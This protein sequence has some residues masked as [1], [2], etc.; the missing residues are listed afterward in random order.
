MFSTQFAD[1]QSNISIRTAT[2][3]ILI[4][5]NAAKVINHLGKSLVEAG[6]LENPPPAACFAFHAFPHGNCGD[7]TVWNGMMTSYL[8]GFHLT[9]AKDESFKEHL[10]LTQSAAFLAEY[11]GYAQEKLVQD[12]Q[13]QE[14]VQ[15]RFGRYS[16]GACGNVYPLECEI[17]GS[18]RYMQE[19]DGEKLRRS[20]EHFLAELAA[21]YELFWEIE[22][23]TFYI[24]VICN[25][26][27]SD[28]VR[29][30]VEELGMN[31]AEIAEKPM[32]SSDDFAF[33]LQK[34]PGSYFAMYFGTGAPY[35]PH[36]AYYDVNDEVLK[37]AILTMSCTAVKA[38][39]ELYRNPQAFS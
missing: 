39:A 6:A 31:P 36:G 28:I 38:L 5:G 1:F 35:V 20:H 17:E 18:L 12:L 7:V 34:C 14:K 27:C 4:I 24:P 9:I 13:T 33:F 26:K 15:I 21:K 32:I 11:F 3:E 10:D 30:T 37:P 8:K 16:S 29:N 25:P 22:Y 2:S 19:E 23:N